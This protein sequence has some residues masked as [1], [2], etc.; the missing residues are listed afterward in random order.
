M[1]N[2]SHEE[3]NTVLQII[4][5]LVVNIWIIKEVRE[6]YGS[7]A[8]DQPDAIQVWAETMFWVIIFA[9]VAGIIMAIIGTIIFAIVEAAVTGE[10]DQNFISDERDKMIA[11]SGN[12]V[13][14]GFTG[15]GFV[16]LIAGIKFGYEP[17]DCLIVLMFCYSLGGLFGEFVK[18]GRYR[19]SI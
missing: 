16:A 12:K 15:A 11:N 19:M 14:M 2:M 18:L 10:A 9:V 8:M 1:K 6:L 5:G 17:I 7:G 13:T 4:I 3:K